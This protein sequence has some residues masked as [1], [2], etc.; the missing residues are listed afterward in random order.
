MV[1]EVVNSVLAQL[2]ST[3]TPESLFSKICKLTEKE[4][5]FIK[6]MSG[7]VM[8]TM[9]YRLRKSTEHGSKTSNV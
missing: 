6:Y 5:N 1:F 2:N 9:C 4:W 3:T 7:Y 8:K